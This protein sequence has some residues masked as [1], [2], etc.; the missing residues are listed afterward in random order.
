MA[1]AFEEIERIQ[2]EAEHLGDREARDRAT[3]AVATE[4]FFAG[5]TTAAIGVLE[6]LFDRIS[7]QPRRVRAEICAQLVVNSFFGS[8]PVL[9]ALDVLDRTSQLRQDFSARAHDLRVR[10]S[11]L[12]MLGRFDEARAMF[13]DADTLY[14]ELGTPRAKVSTGQ[15]VAETLRLEGRLDDAERILREMNAS[16]EAMGET[17]FNSTVC[18]LLSEV[19]CDQGRFDDAEAFASR[20]RE[21]SA[22]DDFASQSGWRIAQARVLADRGRVD[23]GVATV[24]EA[25]A[26]AGRTDYLDWQARCH[27][28]RGLVLE[29]GGRRGDARIAYE[30][31]LELV[32]RKGIV[33]AA[34][35]VRA[36]LGSMSD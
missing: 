17:G 8:V 35:R 34:S 10:G 12:G 24:D 2:A 6:D 31:A 5:R 27:E 13:A 9:D 25:I 1:Q 26:I 20:S 36:R 21:L 29:A 19:L 3:L 7:T 30:R 16:Y 11:L 32:E 4:H 18:S 14:D 28:A 23:E 33:V 15:V 22:E